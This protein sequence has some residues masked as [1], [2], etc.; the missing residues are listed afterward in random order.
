MLKYSTYDAL[1]GE[2]KVSAKQTYEVKGGR[3][4]KERNTCYRAEA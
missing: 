1:R 4:G 2:G 3:N